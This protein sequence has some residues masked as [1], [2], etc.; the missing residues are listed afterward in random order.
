[1]LLG[2]C[3]FT[4]TES[5]AQCFQN[6]IP[7]G[8]STTAPSTGTTTPITPGSSI[9]MEGTNGSNTV[10]VLTDSNGRIITNINSLPALPNGMN[11]IGKIS[12]TVFDV[13][14]SGT[15]NVGVTGPVSVTGQ[16][17][18]SVQSV[19][20]SG[21]WSTTL[22]GTLP[23]FAATPTVNLGTIG[24]IAT[25]DSV[26]EVTTALGTPFQVGGTI[27]NTSF[28]AAQTGS[29]TVGLS[30]GTNTIGS[31]ANTAFGITGTLPGFTT[32]PTVNIGSTAGLAL[33]SS[34]G[35]LFKAGQLIGNTSFDISGTLPAF[36]ATPTFNVGT[37][38]GLALDTSVN[39]LFKAG[40]SIGNTSFG[41]SGT[42]PAFASTPTVNIGS[43]PV[44]TTYPTAM[45]ATSAPSFISG[46]YRQLSMTLA[47]ALR[48]D[49]SG[50]TQPVT[51]SVTANIGTV[52]GLALDTTVNGLFKAGQ[53]IGNSFFGARLQDASGAALGTSGN[54][55]YVSGGGGGGTPTGTAGTPNSAVV[56]VQ[57]ISGGTPLPVQNT[58]ALPAGTN[59]IG[60]V[61]INGT[62]PVS[63][64]FYQATQPVS[65][66]SLP[67]PSGAATSALQ[68]TMNTNLT[69]LVTNTTGAS[70]AAL[71]TS[72]N[73]SLTT[74]AG[75]VSAAGTPASNAVTVQQLTMA[76]APTTVAGASSAVL[77]GSA[78]TL[79][80]INLENASTGGYVIAYDGAVPS[81]GA[82][83]T[84]SLIRY[85]YAIPANAPFDK[86]FQMPAA[87]T[88]QITI[89]CSSSFTTYTPITCSL[90]TGQ[91][92]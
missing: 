12:N 60:N 28:G 16:F 86:V 38:N 32:P 61:N 21:S 81:S 10:P 37:T 45:V 49:N 56:S 53:S 24:S 62:V 83:I 29:W 17:Y 71:Q 11:T 2:A 33:D 41:I 76:V 43:S 90:I 57:G 73:A 85:H 18:P 25:D 15:W 19:S 58:A 47:G 6:G 13:T 4:P 22:T 30:S 23:A 69:T 64:T 3:I 88:T 27:G 14:Q 79:Y 52:N 26:K 82:S 8:Q 65:V 1:M 75:T 63:G 51:G 48:V 9:L 77:K 59:T 89:L 5:L 72:G 50:V 78:G 80:S 46:T 55:V 70:T 84:A 35:G 67:L 92:K 20:Q 39:G 42:L 74:V 40:Q 91:A 31:I 54:P 36:A 7:C 66:A 44:I 87:F 68:G 34:L